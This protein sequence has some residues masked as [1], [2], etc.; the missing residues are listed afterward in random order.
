VQNQAVLLSSIY[1]VSVV[2]VHANENCK[3]IEAEISTKD[4]LNEIRVYYPKR[5]NFLGSY[6]MAI[7]ALKKG[8]TMLDEVDLIHGHIMLPKGFLFLK[9]KTILGKP[10]IVTEHS[11]I[12]LQNNKKDIGLRKRLILNRIKKKTDALIAVS[13]I[14]EHALI[15]FFPERDIQIIGN[16]IKTDLFVLK[17][18]IQSNTVTFLHVSTLDRVNKNPLGILSAVE[19]LLKNGHVNFCLRIVSDENYTDFDSLVKQKGLEK[20]IEFYGPCSSEELVRHYHQSHAFIMFSNYE[21]FSIVIGEAW[22]SGLPVISTPVGIATYLPDELGIQV[23][24]NDSLSL[25]HAM[26]RIIKGEQ[27][28]P[29]A[30]RNHALQY[31]ESSILEKIRNVYSQFLG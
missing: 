17:P 14:L 19:I 28:D 21:T 6:L 20:H 24:I 7:R 23:I 11:S 3:S 13:H 18:T 8:L 12:F 1:K 10:L 27:F 30:I 31:S 4:C 2:Y 16:P 29:I 5:S 9:A 22:S 25:A 15:Q 26:E